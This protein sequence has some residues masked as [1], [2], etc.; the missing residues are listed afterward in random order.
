MNDI[1]KDWIVKVIITFSV[2]MIILFLHY[3]KHPDF[4][5]Y[6]IPQYSSVKSYL[7]IS[8][9][10]SKTGPLIS[11]TE[12][13]YEIYSIGHNDPAFP[14]LISVLSFFG[15]QFHDFLDLQLINYVLFLFSLLCLSLIFLRKNLWIFGA[16]QLLI[17]FYYKIGFKHSIHFADQH[18]TVPALTILTFLLVDIFFRDKVYHS[19][20]NSLTSQK[21]KSPEISSKINVKQY[22]KKFFIL[23]IFGGVFG[24]FRNY[25]TYTFVFL[26]GMASIDLLKFKK[27]NIRF[28]M[29]FSLLGLLIL[30]NFSSLI[31]KGFYSYTRFKNPNLSLNSNFQPPY[32]HGIW[33]NL[34]IGLG[35]L[36]NKWGIRWDDAIGFEHAR[37]YDPKAIYP[38]PKHYV[39]MRKLYFKYLSE[40]PVEYVKNHI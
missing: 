4:Y 22:Y 38:D 26:L 39:V 31:Q 3:V 6:N 33:H 14:I 11:G 27:R 17:I 2:I 10:A 8:K 21:R 5:L 9:N 34:Y 1:K 20:L 12:G 32:S 28:S 16:S 37:R 23:S 13:N 25:F 7:E 35:F 19:D 29:I 18:G 40:E 15:I 24:M 30:L 36:E